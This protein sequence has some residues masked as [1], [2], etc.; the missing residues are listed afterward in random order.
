MK[1]AKSGYNAN[2]DTLIEH[3]KFHSD[4]GTLKYFHKQEINLTIN[5]A[6]DDVGCKGE[7]AHNLG[8]IPYC[9]VY[10]SVYIG[11][12]TGIYEYCPFA[13]AGATI[14]YDANVKITDSKIEVYGQLEG[15][16]TNLWHFDFIV[17]IFNND[18]IL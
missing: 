18:L 7:Y 2:T 12:P 16:G 17:F 3:F 4:Y 8:Y 14:L 6:S 9:E 1:V 11:S 5:A 10:V 13:G 15:M